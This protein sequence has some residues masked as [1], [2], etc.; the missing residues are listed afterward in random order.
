[1]EQDKEGVVRSGRDEVSHEVKQMAIAAPAA[2][3]GGREVPRCE[4]DGE[5]G[6][7]GARYSRGSGAT[8]MGQQ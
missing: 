1:M 3:V 4:P 7:H 8:Q 2:F 6:A 5:D